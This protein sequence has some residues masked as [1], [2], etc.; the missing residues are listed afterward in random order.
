MTP[1]S[2]V[3]AP[4]TSAVAHSRDH[5]AGVRRRP[6]DRSRAG[7]PRRANP[8]TIR[9][10]PTSTASALRALEHAT[11]LGPVRGVEALEEVAEGLGAVVDADEDLAHARRRV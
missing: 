10:R 2:T 1:A 5:S 3:S 6:T 9:S 7:R 8:L 4:P 11:E